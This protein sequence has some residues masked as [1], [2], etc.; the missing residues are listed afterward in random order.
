MEEFQE[1][2]FIEWFHRMLARA[3]GFFFVFG[4]GALAAAG[5]LTPRL[6]VR[7]AGI[8]ML[9][10]AQGLVG[11]W[12][13]KSGFS[14][15]TTENK[16]PRVSPYRLAFHLVTAMALYSL[17]TWHAFSVLCAPVSIGGAAARLSA[18]GCRAAA[19]A[20]S[21]A[22]RKIRTR[23]RLMG[24]LL[25]TTLVSGAF[26]AGNDAGH[27]Y[28]TWPKMLDDWVPPEVFQVPN[29]L[30]KICESTA[31]VQFNHRMLAYSTFLASGLLFL[32]GRRLPLPKEVKVALGAL[33]GAALVQLLLG[34]ATLLSFVPTEL[35]VLHQG[36]GMATL[37][38]LVY[39]LHTISR[40]SNRCPL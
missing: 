37:T 26:V 31:V 17:V 1:I 27:A 9:G 8:G 34:I 6:G 11:W 3:T 16:M 33:H 12:M 2:Y 22:V 5:A 14:E 19:A 7:L 32:T 10:A 30:I 40:V 36:G 29:Q 38:A 35:G 39:L 15:P 24:T 18:K 21:E 25:A 20:V 13:V 23:A 28:N 4:A